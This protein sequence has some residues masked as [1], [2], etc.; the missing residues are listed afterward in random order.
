MQGATADAVQAIEGIGRTIG[1]INEIAS[2]ISIA[3]D[4]QGAATREIAR[5][6]QEAAQGTGQVSSNISGVN[7]AADKTGSAA[8]K[9]L[10]SAEQLSGQAATLRADVDRFLANIRA[11]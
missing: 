5:N 2:V 9:V 10:S 8:G 6:V 1:A 11:A 7:Q 4:Q 3:V